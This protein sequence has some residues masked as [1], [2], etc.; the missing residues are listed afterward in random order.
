MPDTKYFCK[1]G[2][3]R[4]IGPVVIIIIASCKPFD[5]TVPEACPVPAPALTIPLFFAY[6]LSLY[7]CASSFFKQCL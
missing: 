2:Y 3:A 7:F 4:I 1:N 6:R 5:V